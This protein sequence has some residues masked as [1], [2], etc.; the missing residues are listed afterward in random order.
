PPARRRSPHRAATPQPQAAQPAAAVSEQ[1]ARSDGR[2]TTR[3]TNSR[4]TDYSAAP[5]TA[6]FGAA[7]AFFRV[8]VPFARFSAN[9]S[10]AS[11]RVIVSGVCPR[12]SE[13]LT[14]PSVTYG[15]KR[16]SLTT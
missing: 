9:I 8:V 13:T 4:N 6:F 11:S 10:E 14:S 15:P 5:A 3:N 2:R 7:F 1:P 16:P 12:R